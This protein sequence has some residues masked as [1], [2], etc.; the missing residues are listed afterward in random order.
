M[1]QPDVDVLRWKVRFATSPS[2]VYEA[3]STNGG[4]RKYWAESADE[5]DG[6]IHYVFLNNIED[7]GEVLERVPDKRFV[8][9]YFGSRTVFDLSPDGS[10]GT[11]MLVTVDNVPKDERMELCAGW[12]SWLLAMKAAVDFGVDLRNHDPARTWV[13]G[14]ADN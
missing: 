1:F 6:V 7:K 3:L 11:D 12:V 14:Y 10:G 13:Q 9:M 2:G 4:R 8:V 5:T